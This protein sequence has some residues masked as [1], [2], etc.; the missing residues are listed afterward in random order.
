V[1]A[2]AAAIGLLIAA[3]SDSE[4]P[5]ATATLAAT[6]TVTAAPTNTPPPPT[7][8]P[9]PQRPEASAFPPD[10]A[11]DAGA[12]AGGIAAL[13]GTSPLAPVDM[14]LLSRAQARAYYSG[15][16][17]DNGAGQPAEPPRLDP[18]NEVYRLLGLVAE[19]EQRNVEQ[20]SVDN[21]ISLIT[22]FYAPEFKAFYMLDE[23]TGGIRGSSARATIAHEYVHALQDQYHDLN[24][25]STAR[26]SDWDAYRVLQQ[27]MEG[28]A[29]YFENKYMGFSLRSTY[30]VP[31]CFQVPRAIR[32]SV[33]FV[34]ERELDTWYEDGLCFLDAVVP[35]LPN[36][37]RDVW[38]N[39]PTTTEQV[40]HPE[41][42]LA[43]EG[44]RPVAL[45]RLESGLG[46]GWSRLTERNFGEFT[47]QNLL[48]LG[49]TDRARVWQAA[50]GWGGD[51]WALYTNGDARLLQVATVWDTV[52][53][54]QEF[55]EA[56]TESLVR[57]APGQVTHGEG[58]LRT[59]LE[60]REWR[61]SIFGD[62]IGFVVSNDATT[63][64]SV[65]AM[66]G[67]P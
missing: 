30:R 46:P 50:A 43:G 19:R 59:Q 64:D 31:V 40:L 9:A 47:L 10:L 57:R 37:V 55:W 3:C 22:G 61:A 49:L 1:F 42:Y 44:A 54:A 13:R 39:L 29:L 32:P 26:E 18:K 24:A 51:A 8:T 12:I 7:P 63:A 15:G 14:F 20:A 60:G 36:G 52:D 4:G 33:P 23:I 56:L 6:P 28:D 53:E 5:P 45:T 66:L 11:A 27:I 38:E 21:L 67:L 35:S 48:L 25:L 41:K 2:L 16:R 58:S 17:P 65:A 62:R 34:V